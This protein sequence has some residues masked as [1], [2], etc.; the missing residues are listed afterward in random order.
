MGWSG[1]APTLPAIECWERAPKTRSSPAPRANIHDGPEQMLQSKAGYIDARPLTASSAKPLATHGR[2]IHWVKLRNTR[3]E[4]IY[5]GLPPR[6]DIGRPILVSLRSML[7]QSRDVSISAKLKCH[8]AASLGALAGAAETS[9]SQRRRLTR[10]FRHDLAASVI[11]KAR[12]FR[13][14][15]FWLDRR[16]PSGTRLKR[17]WRSC[18]SLIQARISPRR[19]FS[20]MA[21]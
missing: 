9:I 1:R 8:S 6:T 10:A 20:T 15:G 5:S 19:L 14:P 12:F 17:G 11:C 18:C 16:G 4:E 3:H 7:Q 2:T 13:T 21:A